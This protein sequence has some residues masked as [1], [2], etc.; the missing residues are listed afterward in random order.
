MFDGLFN[1]AGQLTNTLMQPVVEMLNYRNNLALQQ[2]QNEYNLDM[3]KMQNEYNS[4]QAQ[5]QRF[6]EAGLN[7][8]LIY[9]QGSAGNATNAPYQTSRVEAPHFGKS[10]EN[11]AKLFNIEQLRTL[12][13][14]R[15]E[16]EAN[17]VR[18]DAVAKSTSIDA[19][20][21][22]DIYDAEIAL[23]SDY[24]Y[25]P[26][27]GQYVFIGTNGQ[28]DV[29]KDP[30]GMGKFYMQQKLAENYQKTQL[31]PY[32]QKL[33]GS[34][35]QY[36]QPQIFMSNYESS[37]YPVSY[38]IGQGSKAVHGLSEFTGMFN[39]SRYILP[40]K[41]SAYFTPFGKKYY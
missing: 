3:W 23:G 41:S 11:I 35:D 29:K 36:L 8:N 2:Q 18:A 40:M 28:S 19:L 17:A 6:Q 27:T 37:H 25:N 39:P 1:Y 15:K 16:A 33:L 7:P 10:A 30:V 34:Q 13:A 4:P 24:G 22:R 14:N 32:R 9:G 12:V 20:R 31:I 21:N 26:A 38:W 5:M